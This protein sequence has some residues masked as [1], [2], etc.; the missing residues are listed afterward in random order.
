VSP[1]GGAS[2]LPGEAYSA[3][4]AFDDPGADQWTATVD[5]GDGPGARPLALS[6]KTF[7]LRHTY[8]RAGTYTVAVA[9]AD[10][11]GG[12][13]TRAAT[14]VVQTPQAA[15]QGVSRDV[16]GLVAAGTIS[17][18][19]GNALDAKL[20]AASRQLDAGN[21][22]AARNQLG[23]FVNQV[24][25]MQRSR[26]LPAADASRLTSAARRIVAAI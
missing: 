5:Y 4:G 19:N 1:L 24:E 7:R 6:G 26:R 2:L 20:N 23:A 17:R 8:D 9:I 11:D 3:E 13:G 21:G 14:V 22:T 10:D 15:L 12:S 25:A 18:G 16:A